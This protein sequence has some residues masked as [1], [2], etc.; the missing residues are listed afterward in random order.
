MKTTKISDYQFFFII[1]VSLTSLTFF[2]VPVQLVSQVRQDL[3]LSMAIG[4][5]IDIYVAFLLTWLGTNYAGLS[6]VQY[7]QV[8]LGKL[9]GK[10][11][12]VVFVLFFVGVITSSMWIF[13]DFLT[14]SLMPETPP[15][16]IS[17]TMTLCA[18]FAAW[19]GIE[20]IARLAQLV[21][22]IILIASILLF[23]TSI[24]DLHLPN[25]LPQFENGIDPAIRGSIYPG[26]WFGIC[27]MMG[28]LIPHQ[29]ASP[30][31]TFQM[32]TYAV[33]LG[34]CLMTLNLLYSIAVMGPEMAQRL[35]NPIYTFTRI[36]N[37]LIFERV[38]VLLLLVYISGSFITISTLYFVVSEGTK[39]VF[40]T[41]NNAFLLFPFGI[42][43]AICPIFPLSSNTPFI[44]R[45]FAYWFPVVAL[46][47]EGGITTLLFVVA[48]MRQRTVRQ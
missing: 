46:F 28:M 1:F 48:L 17:L 26:S 15:L 6:L 32:K 24:P 39:Q 40:R 23:L 5:L 20:T 38:E 37:F 27:M 14:R 3:W 9:A 31:R 44:D 18:G 16:V 12:G 47:I 42:L 13:S 45:Y 4:T 29:S 19:A 34:S 25:L 2:S 33:L 30:K 8:I 35:E 36:T 21:G 10:L 11:I 7:P 43:F 41:K 22:V